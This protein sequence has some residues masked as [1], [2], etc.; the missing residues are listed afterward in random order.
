MD[1]HQKTVV[2]TGGANGIGRCIAECFLNAGAIVA[3]IDTD[4]SAGMWLARHY[5]NACLFFAGDIT[6]QK[7]LDTFVDVALNRLGKV[8]FLINNAMQPQGG[9]HS[10]C[11]YEDFEYALR[12][13]V[14]APYYLALK[15]KDHLAV[16]ASIV[17]ISSSRSN[18]SQPDTESYTAAKGGIAALTHALS[19]SLAGVARVNAVAPGWIDTAP[20]HEG[21]PATQHSAADCSQHPAKRI[22]TPQDIANIVLFLCSS[23]AGFITGQEI[24]VDGGMSKLMVYHG[25]NGWVYHPNVE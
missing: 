17:H 20:F 14:T 11:T 10:G 6:I 7:T 19:V 15:F 5:G 8:H 1:F 18:Q 9:I 16:G 24:F 12:A 3:I 23:D 25:D 2:I 13:G 22:G 4:E 21:A